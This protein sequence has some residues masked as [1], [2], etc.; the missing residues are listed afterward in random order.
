MG[1]E[2]K[3]AGLFCELYWGTSLAEAWSFG[4]EQPRVHAA[5]DETAPL[6][7]Y[8]FTL[9]E[10]PFLLA[11]RTEGGYRVFV[12]PAVQVE[13]SQRKDEF[14][15]LPA[16]KLAQ[17]EGRAYVDLTEDTT[18]RL[19]QGQLTLILQPSVA[20]DRVAGHRL[21][22]LAWL[23]VVILLFLSAPIGFLIAGPDPARQAESNAR[24]IA[25]AREKEAQHRRALGVDTPPQPL[26]EDAQQESGPR[27]R[28]PASVGTH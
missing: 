17:H 25:A 9:P 15:A 6:P 19:T 8:G 14:R 27:M 4:P 28:L 12:P 13:R 21:R 16:A 2:A 24:A 26:T 5:P 10:E 1:S 7:L 3:N 18:L 11:E 23:A 20:K 22:D